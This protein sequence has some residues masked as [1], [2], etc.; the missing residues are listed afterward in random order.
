MP[1]Q[2]LGNEELPTRGLNS[3]GIIKPTYTY[4]SI[5]ILTDPLKLKINEPSMTQIHTEILSSCIGTSSIPQASE[6]LPSLDQFLNKFSIVCESRTHK[7][8]Q[9][10]LT[11]H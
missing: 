5:K 10:T 1:S 4:I 2:S 8:V 6:L 11:N 9:N 3:I 7:F